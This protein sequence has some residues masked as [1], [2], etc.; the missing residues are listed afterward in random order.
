MGFLVVG[1]VEWF[2][3]DR[4]GG[5]CVGGRYLIIG[6]VDFVLVEDFRKVRFVYGCSNRV[7]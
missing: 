7:W 1:F 2:V 6:F 5:T 4:W 3:F